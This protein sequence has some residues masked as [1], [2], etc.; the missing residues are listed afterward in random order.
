MKKTVYYYVLKPIN[1]DDEKYA[2]VESFADDF[3]SI[4]SKLFLEEKNS[5]KETLTKEKKI[6]YLS[7]YKYDAT[8]RIAYIKVTSA[9][10]DAVRNVVNTNTLEDKTELIKGVSDGEEES[11][12]LAIKFISAKKTVCLFESNYYGIGFTKIIK[13]FEKKIKTA[14]KES[15]DGVYYNINYQNIVSHDFLA[16]LEKV[17]RVKMVTLEVDRKALGVSD[18]KAFADR[19]DLSSTADIVFKPCGKGATI[20][21]D[22]VKAFFKMYNEDGMSVRSVSVD[23]DSENKEPIQFNT[24]QMKEKVS[25]EVEVDANGEVDTQS[26]FAIFE[27]LLEQV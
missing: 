25:K 2:Q 16:A 13:Y 21:T 6:L 27:E 17:N 22:T 7:D 24:E 12:H 15:E 20:L 14:H 23:A 3:N 8:N 26:M 9:K 4:I 11:N 19:A 5:R 18:Q 1:I 10:Y